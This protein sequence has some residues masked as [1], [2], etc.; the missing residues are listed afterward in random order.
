M[1]LTISRTLIEAHGGT[2]RYAPNLGEGSHSCSV[3]RGR[4][5][6]ET[7]VPTVYIVDDDD[8]V[9]E[10]LGALLGRSACCMRVLPRLRHFWLRQTA[11]C[12]A[13]FYSTCACQA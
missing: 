6:D 12:G 3:W 4:L 13:A 11:K 7:Q 8:A 2:L 9:R 1:G 5:R 10:A